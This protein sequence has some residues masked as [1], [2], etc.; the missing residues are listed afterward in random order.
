MRITESR[1]RMS[2]LQA[3]ILTGVLLGTL[4]LGM[5]WIG[6]WPFVVFALIIGGGVFYEWN[7]LTG[8]QQTPLARVCGWICYLV[9]GLVMLA[10]FP[11]EVIFSV[12]L[13]GFVLLNFLSGHNAGWVACGF[14]Y[15]SLLAVTLALLR[16][17]EIFGFSSV[18]FLY[19]V[20]W[21][22]DIGAYFCGHA[23][24]GPKLA[25]RLSP[26]KTWSGAIGGTATGILCGKCVALFMMHIDFTDF[27]IPVL[28]LLLSFI[29]QIGDICESSLKRYFQVKDSG[30]ILPGHGG[31][32]DRV[33]SLV[34]AS[35]ALYVI[36]GASVGDFDSPS[37]L[38][39]FLQN[40][41]YAAL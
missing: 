32:M 35:V 16:G 28:A 8:S 14:A 9:I 19:A 11:A 2:N 39:N 3:R 22:T 38:F 21:G 24:R 40:M 13:A 31:V 15:S 41:T 37:G 6:K 33:D 7:I 1:V 25:P 29:S 26:N 27:F 5:T 36:G 20:V 34:A 30:R 12:L 18:C 17:H 4:V 10:G 23:F